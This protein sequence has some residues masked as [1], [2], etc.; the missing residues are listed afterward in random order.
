MLKHKLYF[1]DLEQINS[2]NISWELLDKKSILVTGG[3]GLI[4]SVLVDSMI[5]RNEE[6]KSDIDIWVLTRNEEVLKQRFGNYIEKKYFH[7]LIQDV[8][9]N[10]EIEPSI[11]FII[12]GAG[13]GD[14]YSFAHDPVGVMNANYL[15]AYQV[16][17]LSRKKKCKK[18]IFLS[19]G[20]VYGTY[21]K[22]ITSDKERGASGIKEGEYGYLDILNPRS[23]YSSSKRA[24]ETL[25]VSYSK[26]YDIEICIARPCHT[27]SASMLSTDSRVIGEFIKKGIQHQDIIMK[28][29]GIQT[30]SYCYVADTVSALFYILLYGVN[31]KAYN[32]A[33]KNA[34]LTIKELADI[35][36]LKS[37]VS[38]RYEL[39]S[40]T[41]KQG[42][43]NIRN[44]V[45][46]PSL[47]ESLGW[48][49]QY[50]IMDG[51]DRMFQIISDNYYMR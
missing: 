22:E 33:N 38:V 43:S 47:L 2:I 15:G 16:L 36:A 27:Y 14:P 5:Y 9:N 42:Y 17:E 41:E 35:I 44:A 28:S 24:A 12:H 21:N 13:K 51:I 40:M 48:I 29:E 6:K 19:S 4:G 49:P 1:E 3:T 25:Y 8:S 7:Y 18:V 46:D 34:T 20:E 32:I 50:N 26:Q 31:S 23:C 11:D 37:G 39:P 45:L 10:I 30:R